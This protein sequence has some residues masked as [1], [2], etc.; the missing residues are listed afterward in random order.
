MLSLGA[1]FSRD[2]EDPQAFGSRSSGGR[3]VLFGSP[4][5]ARARLAAQPR[6]TVGMAVIALVVAA[7]ATTSWAMKRSSSSTTAS[8]GVTTRTATVAI[9]NIQQAVAA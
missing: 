8:T 4:S 5:W 1:G 7:G 9:G 3:A 2:P 6:W